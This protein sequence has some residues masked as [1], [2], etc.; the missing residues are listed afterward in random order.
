VVEEALVLIYDCGNDRTLVFNRFKIMENIIT[1]EISPN[2][3]VE[4]AI[5]GL[6]AGGIVG[7]AAIFLYQINDFSDTASFGTKVVI[8]A[9]TLLSLIISFCVQV[10]DLLHPNLKEVYNIKDFGKLFPG[11]GVF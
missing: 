11:L 3:S 6:I 8:I 5:A 9:V 4:G 7:V 1:P 10:G 2:K